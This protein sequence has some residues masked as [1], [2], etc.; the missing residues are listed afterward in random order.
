MKIFYELWLCEY[1][2]LI[3]IL[4]CWSKNGHKQFVFCCSLWGVMSPLI[5]ESHRK[6]GL[7]I[8][9]EEIGAS[10]GS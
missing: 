2:V 4:S 6:V 10:F 3:S 1:S 7:K 5:L 8:A 9:S